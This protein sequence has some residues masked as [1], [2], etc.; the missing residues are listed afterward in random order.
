MLR[1][2]LSYLAPFKASGDGYHLADLSCPLAQSPRKHIKYLARDEPSVSDEHPERAISDD[3]MHCGNGWRSEK[4]TR[5]RETK[6]PDKVGDRWEPKEASRSQAGRKSEGSRG[7]QGLGQQSPSQWDKE[8]MAFRTEP[9]WPDAAS[10]WGQVAVRFWQ[11]EVF[12]YFL[13]CR[14]NSGCDLV[15]AHVKVG[16]IIW[17]INICCLPVVGNDTQLDSQTLQAVG[18]HT[19]LGIKRYDWESN[20]GGFLF[21]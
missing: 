20:I 12:L 21:Y 19:W 16:I 5:Q 18:S 4:E 2:H 7:G 9:W 14:K 6:C 8:S 1:P 13:I 10:S 3:K 15:Q 17:F 11:I